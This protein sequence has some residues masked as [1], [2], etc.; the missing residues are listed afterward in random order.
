VRVSGIQR[1]NRFNQPR[2]D[3]FVG[4]RVDRAHPRR[5]RATRWRYRQRGRTG[6]RDP[7]Q[8]ASHRILARHAPKPS[9]CAPKMPRSADRTQWPSIRAMSLITGAGPSLRMSRY[10]W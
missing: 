7:R 10:A 9:L 5:P 4:I 6:S 1:C 3:G 8:S 2:L